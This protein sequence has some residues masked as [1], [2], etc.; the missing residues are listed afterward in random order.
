[1]YNLCS[2]NTLPNP[3]A[4]FYVVNKTNFNSI[5]TYHFLKIVWKVGKNVNINSVKSLLLKNICLYRFYESFR[6]LKNFKLLKSISIIHYFFCFLI[7]VEFYFRGKIVLSKH[8]NG[9]KTPFNFDQSQSVS[10]FFFAVCCIAKLHTVY[11]GKM[12]LSISRISKYH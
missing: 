9:T 5:Q 6:V 1:M 11:Q 4:I 2:L 3:C 8:W 7:S 10:F 12:I